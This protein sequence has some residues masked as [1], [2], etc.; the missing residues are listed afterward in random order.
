MTK[1]TRRGFALLPGL[2][3]LVALGLAQPAR[4]LPVSFEVDPATTSLT[5]GLS[6]SAAGGQSTT[7]FAVSGTLPGDAVLSDD[8][9]FGSVVTQLSLFGGDLS[10]SH[11]PLSI[12]GAG[13]SLTFASS[14]LGASVVGPVV[15]AIPVA[16]GLSIG[17]FRDYVVAL[18]RGTLLVSGNVLSNPVDVSI[19]LALF[20]I[21]LTL[22]INS[23]GQ[24][25]AVQGSAGLGADVTVPI[26]ASSRLFIAGLEA[27]VSLSGQVGL[28]GTVVPEPGTGILLAAGLALT[29]AARRRLS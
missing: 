9:L 19:D 7:P 26:D 18:D 21:E 17:E 5:L 25:R 15:D 3:G 11:D 12:F 24:I 10:A 23:I 13:V 22:P 28:T 4:A 29:A 16:P 2:L 27:D 14:N 6:S 20:P 1:G 8:A